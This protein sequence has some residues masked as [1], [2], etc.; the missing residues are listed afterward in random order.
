MRLKDK[1]EEIGIQKGGERE[2]AEAT[3]FKNLAPTRYQINVSTPGEGPSP[4]KKRISFLILAK[5]VKPKEKFSV[6]DPEEAR[7]SEVIAELKETVEILESK[8]NKM[9]MLVRLKD[10][11]INMMQQKIG[12]MEGAIRGNPQHGKY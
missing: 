12:E 10:D 2:P 6:V 9:E 4:L 11:K 1:L 5:R 7:K 8:I 3:D